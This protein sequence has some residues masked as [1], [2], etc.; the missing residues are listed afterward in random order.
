MNNQFLPLALH[1]IYAF[2]FSERRAGT[3]HAYKK[4]LFDNVFL[5]SVTITKEG[6]NKKVKPGFSYSPHPFV[7]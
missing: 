2:Q 3:N 6:Y 4:I 1:N 5:K 7:D